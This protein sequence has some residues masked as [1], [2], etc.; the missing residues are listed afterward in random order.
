MANLRDI[1]RRIKSVKKTQKI[2]NAMEMVASARLRRVEAKLRASRAYVERLQALAS[3]LD[4]LLTPSEAPLAQPRAEVRNRCLIVISGERGLCGA[5]NANV[6]GRTEKLLAAWPDTRVVAIGQ[7]GV[8]HFR[9]HGVRPIAEHVRLLETI[10]YRQAEAMAQWLMAM[11]LR[12][13]VDEVV[14][15]YHRFASTLHQELIEE[16]LI[17]VELAFTGGGSLSLAEHEPAPHDHL[18]LLL[19][20]LIAGRLHQVLLDSA[21]SEQGAR[22]IAME[23]A[24]DNAAEMIHNLTLLY[25]RKRQA[26]ITT[27]ILEVVVGGESLR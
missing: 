22:R 11:Y 4:P 2:T 14:V 10:T 6:L 17:P 24:T 25:N 21:T 13:E 27:E 9:K 1:R 5:Y 16:R 15:L 8:Q 26:A 3:S 19:P 20:L 18:N 23:A 7:K 12:G